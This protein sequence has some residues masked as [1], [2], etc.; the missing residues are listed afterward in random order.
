[1]AVE[2]VKYINYDNRATIN[3]KVVD[4][5]SVLME[6]ELQTNDLNLTNDEIN[7]FITELQSKIAEEI[8]GLNS[9]LSDGELVAKLSLILNIVSLKNTLSR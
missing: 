8:S 9:S 4:G 1:V 5:T 3:M 7:N 6:Q 2:V